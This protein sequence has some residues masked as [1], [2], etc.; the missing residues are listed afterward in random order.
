MEIGEALY[1]YMKGYSG[2]SALVSAR[3]FPDAVPQGTAY[4]AITYQQISEDE[5]EPFTQP[6]ATMICATYQIDCWGSTRSSA[7]A[8]AKQVRAAFKN[9]SGATGGAGGVTV[10]AV[11]KLSRLENY[12]TDSDG[13]ALAYVVTMDFEIWYQEVT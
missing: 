11:R 8:V 3:V 6:A 1:S 2:I 5:V 4:P 10:N 13:K 9:Y 7:N 12:Y